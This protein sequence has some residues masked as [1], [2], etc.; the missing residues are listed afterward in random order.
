MAMRV[1][2]LSQLRRSA[3]EVGG[4]LGERA[5]RLLEE[6]QERNILTY[7]LVAVSGFTLGLLVGILFAPTSGYETRHRIS[8]RAT[9][10]TTGAR[11]MMRRAGEEMREEAEKIA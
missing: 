5:S 8:E 4:E 3:S 6:A 9:S 11:R 10:A 2:N 1:R 7:A